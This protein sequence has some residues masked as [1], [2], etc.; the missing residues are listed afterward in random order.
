ML[1]A[2]YLDLVEHIAA[3]DAFDW[4]VMQIVWAYRETHDRNQLATLCRL[5]TEWFTDHIQTMDA[6]YAGVLTSK[7][8]DDRAIPC[9]TAD[10]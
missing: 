7:N 1:K 8:V 5:V 3:H 9:L 6:H 2:E 10:L 4:R